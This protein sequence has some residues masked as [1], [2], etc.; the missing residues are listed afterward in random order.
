MN[1]VIRSDG[2]DFEK[3]GQSYI[4]STRAL[5]GNTLKFVDKMPLNVLYVGFILQALPHAKIVCLER[6]P[7]D[8]IVS[9]F[10]QLF[11]ANSYNYNY[12]YDLISTTNF[13]LEFRNLV[14]LW[15]TTFPENFYLVNYEKLVNDPITEAKKLIEFCDLPWQDDCLHID[16]NSAPV[17]TASAVQVRS[18]INNKSVG[19]WRKYEPYLD[20]VKKILASK[21]IT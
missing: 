17:A 20:E 18:P 7:L 12:A 2:I 19:N 1:T 15:L 11:S 16:K 9:N 3:L 6:N 5:T 14:E 10:R 13:Y 4:E 8:T 21:N